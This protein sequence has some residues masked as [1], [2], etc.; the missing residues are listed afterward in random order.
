MPHITTLVM[1][2]D[3]VIAQKILACAY[4]SEGLVPQDTGLCP[5]FRDY[6]EHTSCISR[7]GGSICGGFMGSEPG[8]VYCV[9]GLR[10]EDK[11]VPEGL[12]EEP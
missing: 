3:D 4:G 5:A 6:G 9:W 12:L 8:Y 2:D 1:L 7:S 11:R 10:L